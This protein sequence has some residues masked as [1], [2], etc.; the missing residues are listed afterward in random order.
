MPYVIALPCIGCK[1]QSCLPACPVACISG[2]AS[3]NQLFINPDECIDCGICETECP[4]DAI[5]PADELPEAWKNFAQ[6][7]ADYFKKASG[8]VR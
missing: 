6:I 1:D 2:T 8:S 5:F 7:N 4:V 3:D